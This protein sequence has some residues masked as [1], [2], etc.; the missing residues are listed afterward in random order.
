MS[1]TSRARSFAVLAAA[2]VVSCLAAAG[3]SAAPVTRQVRP[4]NRPTPAA[5]GD[6]RISLVSST[7]D[8]ATGD[9][10]T[11]ITFAASRAS[12]P[13]AVVDVGLRLRGDRHAGWRAHTRPDDLRATYRSPPAAPS[14]EPPPTPSYQAG[15]DPAFRTLT[16]TV[17]DPSLVATTPLRVSVLLTDADDRA[18]Y[19]G[20]DIPFG[21]GPPPA[22][23]PSAGTVLKLR[24]TGAVK[25]ALAPLPSRADQVVRV[26]LR[27]HLIA[28][29]PL[30][31]RYARQRS[32]TLY[33]AARYRHLVTHRPVRALLTRTT[34]A[35]NG[36]QTRTAHVRVLLRRAFDAPVVC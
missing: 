16:F 9:W 4:E 18:I 23:V 19:G 7:V 30:A 22:P 34:V 29:R 35:E 8:P 11:T 24:P 2:I 25:I 21:D 1:R 36:L 32:L 26:F 5:A 10:S 3:A 28:G 27:G 12:V 31:A 20:G 17:H 15:Y 13:D 6:Q 14:A 33:V